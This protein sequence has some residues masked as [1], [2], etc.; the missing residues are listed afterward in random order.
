MSEEEKPTSMVF[1]HC[2]SVYDEMRAQARPEDEG[3]IYEG[4]LTKLF[5]Q[6]QMA[7]PYYSSIMKHLKTMGCVEQI[8]RGGGNTPSRW[9]LVRPPNEESF[10]SFEQLKRP[11]TGKIA[12]VEQR[13]RDLNKK[14]EELL[15]HHND[16]YHVVNGQ[17][18]QIEKLQRQCTTVEQ[19]LRDHIQL[20]A[21]GVPTR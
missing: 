15:G 14:Y 18:V 8:R 16:L 17:A 6:L 9:L 21:T 13:L 4:Y 11:R 3:L 7:T 20:S 1:D 10:R 12:A 19:E 5:G 2:I